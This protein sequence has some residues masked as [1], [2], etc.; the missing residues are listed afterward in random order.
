MDELGGV[1]A[2][3]Y[4]RD[5]VEEGAE[6]LLAGVAQTGLLGG[7]EVVVV[8]RVAAELVGFVWLGHCLAEGSPQGE[9]V[10]GA[11]GGDPQGA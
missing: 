3:F 9:E 8:A 2:L 10:E 1:W 11:G 6:F 4:F 7:E 5:D